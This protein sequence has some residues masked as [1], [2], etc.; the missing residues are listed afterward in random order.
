MPISSKRPQSGSEQ[1]GIS[2]LENEG[3]PSVP[4][5]TTVDATLESSLVRLGIVSVPS[6]RFE[7]GG[8]KYTNATD[9][10]A[11]ATRAARK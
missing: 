3:G 6:M 9:A 10:I 7:W 11:A 8:Y 2:R 1:S 4:A 5:A